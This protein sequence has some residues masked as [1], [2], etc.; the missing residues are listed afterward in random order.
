MY[1][2]IQAHAQKHNIRRRKVFVIAK[3]L[4][5]SRGG[6]PGLPVLNS[7]YGLCGRKVRLEEQQQTELTASVRKQDQTQK[8]KQNACF[9]QAVN[10]CFIS[11]K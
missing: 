9:D 7:P 2:H 1:V 10:T 6:R 4:C 11:R 5:E 8:V 3:E